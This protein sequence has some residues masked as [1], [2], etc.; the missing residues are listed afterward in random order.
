MT[1][2]PFAVPSPM[3]A[4]QQAPYRFGFFQAVRLMRNADRNADGSPPSLRFG[5]ATGL[6]FPAAEIAAL[7]TQDDRRTLRVGFMGLTGPM[8]VLPAHYTEWLVARAQQRDTGPRAFLDIFNHRLIALFWRAWAH[9]R[10]EIAAENG[11][12]AGAVHHVYDL[13]G[14]GTPRLLPR[15]AGDAL[16]ATALAYYSGLVSQR[17]HGAGSLAQVIGDWLGVPVR[18]ETCVGTWRPLP[19]AQRS[20]IGRQYADLAGDCQLGSRYWDRQATV[21]LHVGPL[22]HAQFESLLPDAPTGRLEQ[23]AALARFM[24]GM[25]VDLRIRL[26]LLARDVPAIRLGRRSRL[27]WSTWLGGSPGG[28]PRRHPADEC[29]FHFH[30]PGDPSWR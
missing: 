19:G 6:A 17:P 9:Y 15:P 14:M 27:G 26:H 1:R 29:E 16:P 12:Q 22:A 24:T 5:A 30:A 23:A 4:L 11:E 3:Q 8:G 21:R 2:A 18:V 13:V 10:P 20:R 25:A 28:R 7:D